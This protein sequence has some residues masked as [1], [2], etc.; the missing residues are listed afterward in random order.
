MGNRRLPPVKKSTSAPG[1]GQRKAELMLRKL[2]YENP[3]FT[4]QYGWASERA[5]WAELAYLLASRI[6]AEH[7]PG[8]RPAIAAATAL[9]LLEV[10]DLAADPPSKEHGEHLTLVL[11]EYGLSATESKTVV[12]TLR[13]AATQI[14][15]LLG[16]HLHK[17]LRHYAELMLREL[18]SRF[19]L[20]HLDAWQSQ[21]AFVMWLQNTCNLP[22]SL[23]DANVAAFC[24]E[25][26]ITEKELVDAADAIEL[27]LAVVDDL[28]A[29]HVA[30]SSGKELP[31]G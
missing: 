16:G 26:R 13:E 22:L 1:A 10:G 12:A 30:N 24:T 2:L 28:V 31:N 3:E 27:N 4:E 7:H 23:D 29:L 6:V 18:T 15:K 21:Q 20:K 8:L 5:R 14:H 25:F 11:R 17:F 9:G 19:R